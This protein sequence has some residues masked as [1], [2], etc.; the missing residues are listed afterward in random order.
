MKVVTIG[1]SHGI[2]VKAPNSPVWGRIWLIMKHHDESDVVRTAFQ[3]ISAV[4]EHERREHFTFDGQVVW[5]PH[6]Q[7]CSAP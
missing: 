3:A 2:Q 1:D 6:A 7:I 4:E 5:N